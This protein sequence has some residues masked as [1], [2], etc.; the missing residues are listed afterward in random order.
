MIYSVQG[1]LVESQ[2]VDTYYIAIVECGGIGYQIK[3]THTSMATMEK[4]GKVKFFTYMYVREDAMELFGFSDKTELNCFKQLISVSGVGPKA[5]LSILSTVD[6]AAFAMA[7][8]SGDAKTIAQAKGV[9][10][11]VS[12]RIVLELKDKI[13]NEQ[14]KQSAA[15]PVIQTSAVS[16]G[17][18]EEAILALNALGYSRAEAVQAISGASPD[19]TAEELIKH[20]L[21]ALAG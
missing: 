13:S 14:L 1:E 8:A 3:T 11:K 18:A 5:A 6:P 7:V 12:Q 19:A 15:I 17:N 16:T 20:G 21:K 4:S 10:A 9:G 2:L